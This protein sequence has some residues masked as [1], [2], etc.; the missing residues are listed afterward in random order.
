MALSRRHL[1]AVGAASLVVAGTSAA[2]VTSRKARASRVLERVVFGSPHEDGAGV[3]LT[4]LLGGRALPMLDPFLML[5]GFHSRDPRDYQAGFPNHP[6]RGFE[7]VTIMIDGAIRHRDSVGNDGRI[8]GGGVQWMTAGRGIIHAEMPEGSTTTGD[9]WGYQLWVNLPAKQKWRDP[10]YQDLGASAFSTTTVE[11]GEARVLAGRVGGLRGAIDGVATNPLLVDLRVPAGG[12]ARFD[13]PAGHT[14][15][16]QMVDGDAL[17]G[18]DNK[19]LRAGALGV[20]GHGETIDVR[21]DG[22]KDARLLVFAG[23]PIGEPVARRGPFVMNTD[24]EL[25]QA[26][27]DYRSGRLL[28][29]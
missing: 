7:T 18:A 9:M 15:F 8:E 5:D 6:H 16:L 12:R 13:V 22:G 29:I 20:L 10:R 25:Q 11:D 21:A 28:D 27:D 3:K 17:V 26:Y 14:A 1:L 2:I 24:A 4:K 19:A 23:A